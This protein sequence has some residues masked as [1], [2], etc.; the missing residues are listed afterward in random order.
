VWDLPQCV[1]FAAFAFRLRASYLRGG[2]YF[3]A[4]LYLKAKMLASCMILSLFRSSIA[5]AS[6]YSFISSVLISSA[7]AVGALVA[8][9]RL[10]NVS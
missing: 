3:N 2:G 5:F 7:F 9:A 8:I 1:F 6:K 4:C 10:L